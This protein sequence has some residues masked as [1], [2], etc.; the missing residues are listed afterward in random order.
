MNLEREIFIAIQLDTFKNI[1][2]FKQGLY[3]IRIRISYDLN[4]KIMFAIPEKIWTHNLKQNPKN[5]LT[6]VNLRRNSF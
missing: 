4:N 3:Q 1:E 5:S 6:F 2:L